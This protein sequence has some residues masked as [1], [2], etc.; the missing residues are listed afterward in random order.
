MEV[1]GVIMAIEVMGVMGMA[2][3]EVMAMLTV[4]T[5]GLPIPTPLLPTAM[6]V[7]SCLVSRIRIPAC[8]NL[9]QYKWEILPHISPPC[10]ILLLGSQVICLLTLL[11]TILL[12]CKLYITS[13]LYKSRKKRQPCMCQVLSYM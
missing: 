3:T 1:M 7:Q 11:Y 13:L 10:S 6:V 5:R 4:A 8:I 9:L 12:L 2:G